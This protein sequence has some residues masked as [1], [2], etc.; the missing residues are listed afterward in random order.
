MRDELNSLEILDQNKKKG[1]R[2]LDAKKNDFEDAEALIEDSKKVSSYNQEVYIKHLNSFLQK[3]WVKSVNKEFKRVKRKNQ[4]ENKPAPNW[5]SL[6]NGPKNLRELAREVEL[7]AFYQI[8]YSNLSRHHHA[9]NSLSK[10]G[11]VLG[12]GL[13][14]PGIRDFEGI[15]EEIK[16]VMMIVQLTFIAIFKSFLQNHAESYRIWQQDNIRDF[17]DKL[18]GNN[19]YV[20]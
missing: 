3:D 6:Y 1:Q 17:I 4:L 18:G 11:L 5:Y 2:F 12:V 16:W 14:L 13:L 8:L 19:V 15:Q 7:E 9:S 10:I 20:E